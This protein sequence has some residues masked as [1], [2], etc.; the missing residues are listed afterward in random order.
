MKQRFVFDNGTSTRTLPD[1]SAHPPQLVSGSDGL[2]QVSGGFADWKGT[3]SEAEYTANPTFYVYGVKL[4]IYDDDDP[5]QAPMWAGKLTDPEKSSGKVILQAQ[6]NGKKAHRTYDR[7]MWQSMDLSQ[8]TTAD[9]DPHNYDNDQQ[10]DVKVHGNREIQFKI[11]KKSVF[12]RPTGVGKLTADAASGD[13]KVEV[14]HAGFLKR[15]DT[16]VIGGI[17][18]TV[19]NGY[20]KG[21]TTVPL[22]AALGTAKTTGT[23]VTWSVPSG[24][25]WWRSGVVG[26][27]P[28]VALTRI[29]FDIHK[30]DGKDS[31]YTLEICKA[32]GPDGSL[33][34]VDT[35][36][37]GSNTTAKDIAIT[38]SPDLVCIRLARS[39]EVKTT[40]GYRVR[41]RNVIV[42]G[43]ANTA[44]SYTTSQVVGDVFDWL[45]GTKTVQS[46]SQNAM[47]LDSEDQSLADVLDF[48]ALLEDRVWLALDDGTQTDWRYRDWGGSTGNRI[49][50]LVRPE[51]PVSLVPATGR[52]NRAI[53]P[54]REAGGSKQTLR[55]VASP[56]PMG[57]PYVD[58]D[59][60]QFLSEPYPPKAIAQILGQIIANA[61][62]EL[63]YVGSFTA[64]EVEDS[65]NPGVAVSA[66]RVLPGDKAITT[67]QGNHTHRVSEVHYLESKIQ[68]S[69]PDRHPILDRLERLRPLLLQRG[70]NQLHATIGALGLRK[71]NAP[72]ISGTPTFRIQKKQHHH[73]DYDGIL[74][75][76]EVT[77]DVND[78]PTYIKQYQAQRMYCDSGGTQISGT[79]IQTLTIK[80]R[81]LQDNSDDVPTRAVFR[82]LEHPAGYYVKF[83]AKA[84]DVLHK[85]SD[86]TSWTSPLLPQAVV[87]SAPPTPTI[88]RF[89]VHQHGIDAE[90]DGGTDSDDSADSTTHVQDLDQRVHR[91]KVLLLNPAGTVIRRLRAFKGNHKHWK[92]EKP[93]TGTYTLKV[94]AVN[95]NGTESSVASTTASRGDPATPGSPGISITASGKLKLKAK[96]TGTYNLDAY[97]DDDVDSIR[98][99]L[100]NGSDTQEATI[101]VPKDATGTFSYSHT[102]RAIEPGE[103]ID[104]IAKAHGKDRRESAWSSAT[105]AV[106]GAGV[107]IAASDMSVTNLTDI[108]PSLGATTSGTHTGSTRNDSG[109]TR[110]ELSSGFTNVLSFY[111]TLNANP[112]RMLTGTSFVVIEP[113][114]DSAV[115]QPSLTLQA[116]AS[117]H[118]QSNIESTELYGSVAKGRCGLQTAAGSV[119][120]GDV[121]GEGVTF[122]LNKSSAPGSV[123]FT[124]VGSDANVSSVSA[125][126]ITQRGF[127]FKMTASAGATLTRANR[128]FVA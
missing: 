99:Q 42:V 13:T 11:P 107:N 30:P 123:T 62:S 74:D 5:G 58:I 65:A 93:G 9:S 40:E 26:W 21:D 77:T 14:S 83:R 23:A 56:N 118:S 3:I 36:S 112:G 19:A 102:F 105:S 76:A 43:L 49:W 39:G 108:T 38:G 64:H 94:W 10:I 103:S 96:V 53:V 51:L 101:K 82:D 25:D 85:E 15:G 2:A 89:K 117:G 28:G 73:Q 61:S 81:D 6:G 116:D 72:V 41:L 87:S 60:G 91:Y 71:P 57:T 110:F 124:T 54:Y 17:S 29:A 1:L 37:M 127:M 86:W 113:P 35:V 48:C 68:G 95:S 16:I 104:I 55:V 22:T 32:T 33:T 88:S 100:W 18:R 98:V 44:G 67:Y 121:R 106:A 111:Q 50:K 79:H 47:P 7:R 80:D 59:V 8:W 34:V 75:W 69:F 115:T 52:A 45:G 120:A 125:T 27:Y 46:S 66:S 70:K 119:L 90:W 92:I 63:H 31:D 24:P 128:D 126:D 78:Q 12:R 4:Y 20:N 97:T 109:G 122:V 84:I 114:Y